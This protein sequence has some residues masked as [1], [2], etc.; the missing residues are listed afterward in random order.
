[1]EKIVK[2]I[3]NINDSEKPGQYRTNSTQV[4]GN[5]IPKLYDDAVHEFQ[6]ASNCLLQ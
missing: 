6:K 5:Q 4:L 1:M 2:K 3:K